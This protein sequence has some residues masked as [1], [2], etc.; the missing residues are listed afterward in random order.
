MVNKINTQTWIMLIILVFSISALVAC[1][2]S[3]PNDRQMVQTAKKYLGEQKIREAALE[4]RGALQKNPDNGEARY[5]LGQINLD[6]GDSAGAEKEFRRARKAGWQEE[7]ALIGLARALI[8]GHKFQDLMD[9]V[10][11]KEDYSLITRANLYGLRAEALVGLSEVAQASEALSVGAEID[12]N[13][14]HLLKTTIQLRLT[15]EDLDSTISALKRALLVHP[16]NPELLLLSAIVAIQGK[17]PTEAMDA[18]R[19]VIDQDPPK[20]FT[21][22]GRQARLR[23]VGLEILDQKFDQAQST[24]E[25][26]VRM[27]ANDP[28][29]NFLA[30]RLT[31]ALGNYER[32]E[33]HLLKV[34][35]IAPDHSQTHLL[36][37]SVNFAQQDFEQ[38]AYYIAKYLS[39]VPE[40][41]DARKLLGRAY[42]LLGQQDEAQ[43]TLQKGLGEKGAE[44]A[45]LLA[46]VGLSQL[47]G[48]D[49]ASGIEG[50]EH[51]LKVD[52]KKA[53]LRRELAKAY[54]STGEIDHA[55]QELKTILTKDGREEQT[56][57]LLVI[58]YLRA[59]NFSQ[60]INTVLD[61][62][63][64]SPN[65]PAVLTL[66]GNVFAASDDKPEARKYFS[67]ALQL[68]SGFVPAT[69]SL[70]RLE[71]M[72]GNY[73]EAEAL[74]KGI[75]DSDVE[76]IA[77][78]L[79]LARLAES[80][81]MTKEMLDW[82]KQARKR[83]PRDIKP[84]VMLAE[85]YLREKQIKKANLLI[86][87]AIK[88]GSR[89][90]ILLILQSRVMIANERY[91]EALPLLTEIV[92]RE[93][94][95]IFARALLS[96][97]HLMLGQAKDARRQLEIILEKQ[98]SYI[99][100]L[101]L[102]VRMELQSGHYEQALEFV[103]QIQKAQP[104]LYMGYE[105][106]GDARTARKQYVEAKTAYQQA[107]NLEPS[108]ALAIKLSE[109]LKRSGKPEDAPAALLAWL[110]DHS[111]DA[112]SLQFLGTSYQDLGQ[113]DK[114]ILA[115][116][117]VLTV[118]PD[119]MVALNNLAWLYS[120]SNDPKAL[121]LAEKAYTAY[122]D[123]VGIQD[124][125][126]WLLVQ[127]GQVDKGL[128]L[129]KQAMEKL[130][131]VLEVRY[132]YAVALL[133][134]GE[135]TEARKLLNQL[136]QS[137]GSFEGQEDI[138][139]LLDEQ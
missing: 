117:K 126:G 3:G 101:V 84:R 14:F 91:N 123:N 137:K 125:Y 129:L 120:L 112:R 119:N 135:K 89:Q 62:Q 87:E 77:P 78:L 110:N 28:E 79:A 51:A 26:L 111:D 50:L 107:W 37:G 25:P 131:E 4:L 133:K 95:S 106:A 31:F 40:N 130:S 48:G 56:Q 16:D 19:K 118:Q 36:F 109:T 134:S 138:K 42:M 97:T 81:G 108:A 22:Y 39:T 103:D 10:E 104:D 86:K 90:P 27:N 20:F 33:E 54:I 105:L 68:R 9:E 127:Q 67:K 29:T 1:S 49:T 76:S 57:V 53:S 35:K 30:G 100:A 17:N 136:L 94:E 34:L 13:A 46:L 98:P 23:L 44:D 88:I 59:G 63:A 80:Q 83:A 139:A 38:A 55:I 8:N 73:T 69:M 128:G 72:Q 21:V 71:E 43:A 70:S 24:L 6:I 96:E 75:V 15:R 115:Y 11:I 66:A 7:D 122:P 41:L 121:G 65:D 116:E 12:E 58:A 99:P 32:A 5:L 60:A 113:N 45:E 124:T 47:Q 74:Y 18:Y 64:M 102:I 92:T 82:L 114:A 93:P 132:H 85:Y 2:G 52:P 61:L